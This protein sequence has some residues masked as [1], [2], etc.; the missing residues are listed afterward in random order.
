M[1]RTGTCSHCW[2]SA[3]LRYS[4]HSVRT[5]FFD[6]CHRRHLHR[7]LQHHLWAAIFS[8]IASELSVSPSCTSSSSPSPVLLSLLH[9]FT[10]S[11]LHLLTCFPAFLTPFFTSCSASFHC[12]LP[13]STHVHLTAVLRS[14]PRP[15]HPALTTALSMLPTV[16]RCTLVGGADTA[17]QLSL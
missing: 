10:F 12:M 11:P 2:I 13:T 8:I 7:H 15:L 9:L 6:R 14:R 16:F 17:L 5:P 3:G 4:D 1:T